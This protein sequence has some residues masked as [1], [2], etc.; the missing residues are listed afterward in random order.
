MNLLHPNHTENHPN[1]E[2]LEFDEDV[3]TVFGLCRTLREK[4]LGKVSGPRL[5]LT[6]ARQSKIRARLREGFTQAELEDAARGFYADTWKD[7]DKYLDPALCFRDDETV[8]RWMKAHWDGAGTR[9]ANLQ[10]VTW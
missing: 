6:Q 5:Q 9:P 8:R 4:R 7:R 10:A 3:E 1:K 2:M